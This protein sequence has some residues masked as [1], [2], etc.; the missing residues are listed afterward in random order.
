MGMTEMVITT[1][2]R[3]LITKLIAGTDTCEFTKMATSSHIYTSASTLTQL[4]DIE[5]EVPISSQSRP[6]STTLKVSAVFSNENVSMGYYIRALGL[7][8]ED[9]NG[10]EILFGVALDDAPSYMPDS[11]AAAAF[12]FNSTLEV[13]DSAQVIINVDPGA[14]ALA[15]DLTTLA[16]RV[17]VVETNLTAHLDA[18][19]TD[20]AG[21]HGI[22]YYDDV[23]QVYVNGDW[24]DAGGGGTLT[25]STVQVYTTDPDLYG[26][27]VTFTIA[28]VQQTGTFGSPGDPLVFKTRTLGTATVTAVK[29]AA[30]ATSSLDLST[31]QNV[32]V[33]MQSAHSTLTVT[34]EDDNLIG[35]TVTLAIDGET[36]TETMPV[37]GSVVFTTLKKGT[38]TVTCTKGTATDTETV[39]MAT[40]GEYT[41]AVESEAPY[42]INLTT[43][44]ETLKGK[45][46]TATYG[47][48]TKTAVFSSAGAATM[49]IYG[50]TGSVTFTA[51]DGTDTSTKTIT[52]VSGTQT[53]N[54]RLN[55]VMIYGVEWDGTSTTAFSRTDEAAGFV[56]PVP[57]VNNGNGSSPFDDCM[58]WSGMRKVE[59]TTGGTLV[60]IPKF[61]YKITKNGTRMKIQIADGEEDG[62]LVS[63]LHQ[64]RGDGAG[65]RDVAYVGRYHCANSTYK[66]T[67]GV[68]PQASKTRAEFRTAI[69]NLGSA[70]WQWDQALLVT[71]W[72]LYLVEYGDWNSQA[73]I[74]YGCSA[75]GSATENAGAT[76]GMTYHTGTSAASRTT[77]GHT[78]YRYIEDLWGNVY[79]WIDGIY[80]SGQTV[81]AIKNPA[82]YSDTTG[83]TN[84]GTRPTTSGVATAWNIPNVTGFEYALYP[85]ATVADST[86][87]TYDCDNCYYYAS[88]VVLFGGGYYGQNQYHGL[89]CLYGN[90]AASYQYAGIGGRLQ[91]LP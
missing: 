34:T 57:A 14:Y 18:A 49:K 59:D 69:H 9:G 76:D 83:G 70:Y 45:T 81:Y 79:D 8:A 62:F 30:Q 53:Y 39:A 75:G 25:K 91:K 11:S 51:T 26:A 90:D 86:Y 3:A 29:G 42:V 71:L 67:T 87:S 28:G 52:I 50:Y 36:Q 12:T 63:P 22:R 16:G 74:G 41:V 89:F 24:E 7:Y 43:T 5:Q 19:V 27:D 58:P 88:G 48:K 46:I 2:G 82:N 38:A 77:Y 4:E 56:D 44:E 33:N 40:Y 84:V 60:E 31:Y 20:T 17:T 80:F 21:V 47:V 32:S 73:K 65:E 10:T 85:S 1:S 55:F 35:G 66:S 64:D 61:W 6:S 15:S 13:G 68:K 37:G 72:L 54:V 23:L 78:Q